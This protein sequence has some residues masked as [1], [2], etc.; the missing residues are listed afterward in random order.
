MAPG[1]A[2]GRLSP[3]EVGR[4]NLRVAWQKL[5][6]LEKK[7]ESAEFFHQSCTSLGALAFGLGN[8][9]PCGV[10]ESHLRRLGGPLPSMKRFFFPHICSSKTVENGGLS[11]FI[12]SKIF[13]SF[14]EF[15]TH[16]PTFLGSLATCNLHVQR[17]S[18][19]VGRTC[20]SSTPSFGIP[21]ENRDFWWW[22]AY[23]SKRRD[24][25]YRKI[26]G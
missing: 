16:W 1:M 10:V 2:L 26:A 13:P 15:Q 7:I 19:I 9:R 18:G 20:G 22:F 25:R 11:M 17:P 3:S 4:R 21:R 5:F 8:F 23:E 24:S 14:E 6:F 12:V